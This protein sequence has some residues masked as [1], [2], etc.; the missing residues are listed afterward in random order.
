MKEKE[1]YKKA[2][3]EREMLEKESEA[4]LV[5]VPNLSAKKSSRKRPMN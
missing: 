4:I 5:I 1:E 2:K 3:K